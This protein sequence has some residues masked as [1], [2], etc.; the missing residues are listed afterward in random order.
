M[1]SRASFNIKDSGLVLLSMRGPVSPFDLRSGHDVTF[2]D[3]F[4]PLVWSFDVAFLGV[5][6]CIFGVFLLG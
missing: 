3:N 1:P 6:N 5:Q 2:R 4:V